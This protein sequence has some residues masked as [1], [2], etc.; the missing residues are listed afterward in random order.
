M[1]NQ[2]TAYHAIASSC[3]HSFNIF[4]ESMRPLN[5]RAVDVATLAIHYIKIAVMLIQLHSLRFG[6]TRRLNVHQCWHL[7]AHSTSRAAWDE[8]TREHFSK[9]SFATFHVIHSLQPPYLF[10]HVQIKFREFA[11]HSYTLGVLKLLYGTAI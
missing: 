10:E 8:R 11:F 4:N 3:N 5:I 6:V 9:F 1:N 2:I 7:L